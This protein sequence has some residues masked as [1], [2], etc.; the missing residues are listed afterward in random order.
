MIRLKTSSLFHKLIVLLTF[1]TIMTPADSLGVKKILL[2][3]TITYGLLIDRKFSKHIKTVIFLFLG[4]MTLILF[5]LFNGSSLGA[6]LSIIYP[7]IYILVGLMSADMKVAFENIF[8][9]I[10]LF[11]SLII[12]GTAIL[13]MAHL[14][15]I[16]SN[17]LMNYII[18][19]GEGQISVSNDAIFHYVIFLNGSPLILYNVA[20]YGFKQKYMLL[21][22]SVLG[23]FFSGT[24][25]NIYMALVILVIVVLFALKN[26]L[27]SI[28]TILIGAS[29]FEL[30]KLKSQSIN[31]AKSGGDYARELKLEV[32]QSELGS[33]I[34]NW[35]FGKGLGSYYYG[36]EKRIFNVI[37]YGY[38]NTS[39]WSYMELIRQAGVI[40]LVIV[41][42]IIVKPLITLLS[43]RQYYPVVGVVSYLIVATVDPFLITSTG[44]ILY[45]VTYYLCKRKD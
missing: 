5:S 20:K 7:F 11:L 33:N 1:F 21:I 12:V 27:I 32:I 13:D 37:Q 23:L 9:K 31:Q 40:G 30:F 18:M 35:M 16:S 15:S 22:I 43:Q 38:V 2:F 6:S 8:S 17:S 26:L 10:L 36:P 41:M 42:I 28:F 4:L 29:T 14:V 44:F 39:E 45:A 19:L 24:R 3:L 34:R 25:A